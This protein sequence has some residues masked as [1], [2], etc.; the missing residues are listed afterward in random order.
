MD[1][2]IS[3]ALNAIP[4]VISIQDLD[5]NVERINHAGADFFSIS[6][7]DAPGKKCY[8]IAGRDAPCRNCPAAEVH[9]THRA[10]RVEKY[11]ADRDIWMDARAYP[12]FDDTG[13]M[14]HIIEHLRDFS[15]EKPAEGISKAREDEWHGMQS[16]L[17]HPRKL[18]SVGTLAGGFAHEFNNLMMAVQ[19]HISLMLMD[20]D[21]AHPHHPHLRGIEKCLDS[22]KDL[23]RQLIGVRREG[24]SAFQPTRLN[25]VFDRCAHIFGRN[26]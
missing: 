6:A 24:G 20:I 2:A 16:Q 5:H 9:R 18:A 19:G 12:V 15:H 8:E 13:R 21:A 23:T 17:L 22:A 26:R 4:E 1:I 11:L 3:A 14:V 10:A 7:D 25:D